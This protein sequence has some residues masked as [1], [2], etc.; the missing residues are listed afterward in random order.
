MG[1]AGLGLDMG[2]GL[3]LTKMLDHCTSSIFVIIMEG[4]V[5]QEM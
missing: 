1:M 2:V 5:L 4:S 3:V